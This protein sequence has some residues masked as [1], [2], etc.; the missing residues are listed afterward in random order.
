MAVLK[1][2]PE[3]VPQVL[4]PYSFDRQDRATCATPLPW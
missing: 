3:M 4:P 1:L 2:A